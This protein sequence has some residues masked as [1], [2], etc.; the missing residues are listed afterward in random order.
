M[1]R[2]SNK[3]VLH[4]GWPAFY[5]PACK[6][7][8]VCDDKKWNHDVDRP[9]FTL[10]IQRGGC[11]IDVRWGKLYYTAKSKHFAGQSVDMPDLPYWVK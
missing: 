7:L 2:L 3:L 6:I 11:E 4:V 9:T 5:C 1:R 10:R 8:H